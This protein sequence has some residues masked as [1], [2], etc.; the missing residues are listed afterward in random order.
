VGK[1]D[2]GR[3]SLN[4][5]F[6]LDKLQAVVISNSVNPASMRSKCLF[7]TLAKLRGLLGFRCSQNRILSF[8]LHK[9]G[10]NALM[11]FTDD[12]NALP[13]SGTGFNVNDSWSFFNTDAM[14]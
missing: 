8:A 10:N 6:V 2:I 14:V 4:H 3:E 13:D 9:S 1:T 11:A 5:F 7:D 12:R